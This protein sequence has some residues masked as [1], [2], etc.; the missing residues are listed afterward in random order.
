MPPPSP[1]A[2]LQSSS[3]LGLPDPKVPW[4]GGFVKVVLSFFRPLAKRNQAEVWP[5]FQRL[6][7]LLL[8]TN[9]V[10]W[11]IVLNS[12]GPL[13]HWQCLTCYH[14]QVFGCSPWGAKLSHNIP[15]FLQFP[16]VISTIIHCAIWSIKVEQK[17]SVSMGIF[18]RWNFSSFLFVWDTLPSQLA[19]QVILLIWFNQFLLYL[20]N[21]LIILAMI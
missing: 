12:L 20:S 16:G 7:K 6:L 9:G 15:D 4:R 21:D 18:N 11:V 3:T 8:W 1:V 14:W 13:C 17:T 2:A 5:G 10:E 19:P